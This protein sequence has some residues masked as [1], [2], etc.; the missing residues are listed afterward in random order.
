MVAF[1]AQFMGPVDV[2]PAVAEASPAPSAGT[3]LPG[4]S[5]AGDVPAIQGPG[6][7]SLAL[8]TTP[9]APPVFELAEPDYPV[10]QP[11]PSA[12]E[13]G[14]AEPGVTWPGALLGLAVESVRSGSRQAVTVRVTHYWP[15]L[16]GTN[17]YRYVDG[18]CVS[19]MYSGAPWEPYVGIAAACPWEWKIGNAVAINGRLFLCLDRGSMSCEDGICHVDILTDL[20]V[21]GIF[22]AE[23]WY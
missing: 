3:L 2:E 4:P 6:E 14:Q 18:V 22:E 13:V 8:Q 9:V 19:A 1:T 15:P 7:F 23:R 12:V 20:P 17:C 11:T 5:I 10:D 21:D 16:G